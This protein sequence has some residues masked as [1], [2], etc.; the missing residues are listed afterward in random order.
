MMDN[1]V[2]KKTSTQSSKLEYG[3]I[4]LVC[5]FLISKLLVRVNLVEC[6]K[7]LGLGL[8]GKA[9]RKNYADAIKRTIT[10]VFIILKNILVLSFIICSPKLSD[11]GIGIVNAIVI[12]L[13]VMNV[14]TY[15]YHHLWIEDKPQ[16]IH[17]QR[18]RFINLI[19]AVGFNILCYTYLFY[20]GLEYWISWVQPG[21]GLAKILQY[22]VSNTFLF[23]SCL[24]VNTTFGYY[25]QTSQQLI[26]FVFLAIILG[27][28]IPN[29]SKGDNNAISQ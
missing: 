6:V 25:L 28:S 23:S 15:F 24:T 27:Q 7:K 8:Y 9:Y 29:P 5:D 20:K 11:L 12:Y 4:Y 16:G 22:S 14:F 26:S 2:S 19:L 10:D 21:V 13:M 18:R 3:L 17:C 1:D